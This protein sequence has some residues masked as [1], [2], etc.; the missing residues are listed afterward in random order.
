MFTISRRLTGSVP[1]IEYYDGSEVCVLG[2]ALKLTGGKLAKAGAT[3]KVSFICAGPAREHDKKIPV[4]RVTPNIEFKTTS[5]A[6]VADTLIGTAVTLHTDG[7]Q[8]TA[9]TE[10]G[11]FTISGTDGKDTNSNVCGFFN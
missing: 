5:T 6:T 1:P 7:L 8:V 10:S 9:T 11:V 3:D 4:I 2:E